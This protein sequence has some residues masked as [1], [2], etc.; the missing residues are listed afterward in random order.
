LKKF[1]L[2]ENVAARRNSA[3]PQQS[4]YEA[5]ECFCMLQKIPAASDQIFDPVDFWRC[6]IE[7]FT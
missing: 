1:L 5:K 7:K 4:T 6:Q 2:A 3:K